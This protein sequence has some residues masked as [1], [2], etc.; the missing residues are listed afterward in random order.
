GHA[1]GESGG[2]LGQ[3]LFLEDALVEIVF[4][5]EEQRE[6][7]VAILPDLDGGDVADLG[8]IGA[9]ADRPLVRL[10]DL[11][12]NLCAVRQEGAAPAART[13]GGDR[14]QSEDAAAERDDR[15]MRREIIGGA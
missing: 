2:R 3:E 6:G 10:E 11:E 7:D 1:A 8:E 13:E 15:A 14:G 12:R 5:V 4:G 9:G